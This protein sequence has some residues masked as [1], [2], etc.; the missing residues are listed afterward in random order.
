MPLLATKG[1]ELK[2]CSVVSQLIGHAF[3]QFVPSISLCVICL[4]KLFVHVRANSG[5]T[6]LCMNVCLALLLVCLIIKNEPSDILLPGT[7]YN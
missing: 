7:W 2:A 5:N 3:D 1:L 6:V 4:L